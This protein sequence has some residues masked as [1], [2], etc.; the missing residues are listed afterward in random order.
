MVCCGFKEWNCSCIRRVRWDHF[1]RRPVLEEVTK[2]SHSARLLVLPKR[3]QNILLE[4]KK[5]A[6]NDLV[7]TDTN[8]DLLKYNAVQSAYNAG[9][10]ALGLPWRSTHILRHT[11]A[12]MALMG[13]KNL[14]AVQAVLG[15]QSRE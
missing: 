11:Y 14:S 12:T 6:I 13:T 5:E 9:F 4:M 1:T 3:L 7:F 10:E 15:H 8:G 2:T